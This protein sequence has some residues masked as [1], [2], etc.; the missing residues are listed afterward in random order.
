MNPRK[1][2]KLRVLFIGNSYTYF[3]SLPEMFSALSEAEGFPNE[4]FSHVKG[5]W[6]L[7]KMADAADEVGALVAETLA[8]KRLD[9]VFVQE[10]SLRP[11]TD[12]EKF[13]EGVRALYEK[14]RKSGARTV[15]YETWARSTESED[16]EKYGLTNKS[17]TEG[18]I[19]A[20][21]RIA[22]ELGI[23]V[24]RVGHAFYEVHTHH[25]EIE[26]YDKDKTHP[27]YAGSAL[28]ALVH[29]ATVFR[30]S[31]I[32]VKWRAELER[33]EWQSVLEAAAH[34]AVFGDKL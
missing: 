6:T 1:S 11:V 14:I 3:N 15:M 12:R 25:P 30:R 17:M 7:E 10:Q 34:R 28:A 5:G 29:F 13:F 32:G 4:T 23:E 27:S 18:L 24:S 21:G 2:E 19:D 31:P 9:V 22:E 8:E 33:P 20:Y 16:L 26:L